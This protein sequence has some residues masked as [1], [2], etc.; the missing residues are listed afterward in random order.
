MRLENVMDFRPT[1]FDPNP[2]PV[3]KIATTQIEQ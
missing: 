2:N 3:S 1:T